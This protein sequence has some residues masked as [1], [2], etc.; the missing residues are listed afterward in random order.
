MGGMGGMG[1]IGF[2]AGIGSWATVVETLKQDIVIPIMRTAA[3][4]SAPP[5][6][7]T[8]RSDCDERGLTIRRMRCSNEPL[9]TAIAN[10]GEA[11]RI[12]SILVSACA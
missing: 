10:C 3:I 6:H 1:G 5:D 2:M 9:F 7:R 11:L 12:C 8:S 4:A